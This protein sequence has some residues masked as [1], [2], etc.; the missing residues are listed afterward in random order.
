LETEPASGREPPRDESPS[1]SPASGEI[2]VFVNPQSRANR[3]NPRLRAELQTILGDSGRVLSPRNLAELDEVA[4]ALH[5]APPAVIGV[6]G[7]DGTLHKVLT[8]L[9]RAWGSDPLP[10]LAIL[11]GGT[12]NVVAS[13]LGIRE[14]PATFL[15][16]IVDASRAGRSLPM[17]RRRCLR[18]GQGPAGQLGFVFGNGLL[19]N[20]LT[21]YYARGS[22]SAGS[23]V[24]LI[25]RTLFS[26]MVRG[27]LVRRVFRRFEGSVRVDGVALD[28]EVLIGIGAG[29][30]REIG[31]GFK[32]NHRA[33]DDPQ[34][35]SVVALHGAPL[36]LIMDLT[37]VH[38][39]RG[40]S[41]RRAF[42]TL[43]ST[44]EIEPR[45][46]AETE[47]EMPYTIDGDLY[48]AKAPWPLR[49]SVG[50]EVRVLKPKPERS[51]IAAPRGD[52]MEA[53]R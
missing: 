43:A 3:R 53:G 49:I 38:G 9:G 2:A 27:R 6:H 19:A 22:Y 37:A 21:E 11:C 45:P 25:V 24:W 40:V 18:V 20:F 5:D 8:A 26:A 23:A 4:V 50:P 14:R 41:P 10:P 44:L 29:A 48:L 33:D 1:A 36:A 51:L 31:L 35:F 42:S 47:T 30:V 12:M 15:R 28:K 32:L 52:T 46:Q 39:G 17:L 7:G 34:R 16:T 13:S